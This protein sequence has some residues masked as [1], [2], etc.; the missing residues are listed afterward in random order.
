M[1]WSAADAQ[2][3]PL[4]DN[5]FDA[6]VSGYLLRN[7]SNLALSLSEQRRVLKPG[8]RI[9]AL[10]TAPPLHNVLEPFIRFHL[11]TVIPTL[12]Q[13]I[14]GQAD[15]YQLSARLHRELPGARAA[16]EAP[17][18]CRLCAG[19]LSPPDVWDHGDYLGAQTG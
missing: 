14:T 5:T 4:P 16:G 2:A 13:W 18:G 11:H 19:W 3:L 10:D 9:V 17:A 1:D 6:V 15:A 8:G 7:V 12:G